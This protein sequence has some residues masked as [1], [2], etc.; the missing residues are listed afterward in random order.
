L[1]LQL[2]NAAWL[3]NS[4]RDLLPREVQVEL[5]KLRWHYVFTA[6]LASL[7][8]LINTVHASHDAAHHLARHR[9]HS[10]LT[11]GHRRSAPEGMIADLH[12]TA[13]LTPKQ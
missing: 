4:A 6:P 2:A 13:L 11:G 12:S 7:M 1:P 5:D 8:T 10:A 9:L 3:F